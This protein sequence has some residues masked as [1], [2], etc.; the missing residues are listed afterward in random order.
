MPKKQP[1]DLS[2]CGKV[3]VVTG[4]SRGVGK[5]VA[6][7]LGEAGATVYITGR[8]LKSGQASVPLS[9]T[10]TDTADEITQLGG[11]GIACKCDHKKDA[12]VKAVFAKVAKQQGRLD[13]LVNNA[14]SGYENLHRDEYHNGSFWQQPIEMWDAKHTVGVRSAFVAS[15]YAAP[16]MVERNS[17]LIVNISY[18]STAHAEGAAA[19]A[20]AKLSA[21]KM[22]ASMAKDL[23]KF[24]IAS[25]SLYPGYVRTEGVMRGREGEPLPNTESPLYVGRAAAALA[26]DPQIIKKTGQILLAGELAKEYGF[27]DIDGTQPQPQH[28][29]KGSGINKAA[30]TRMRKAFE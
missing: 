29:V 28:M 10:L 12:Q 26:A 25:V 9:G 15:V 23:R 20:V 6:L 16:L 21:D 7:A 4:A 3:A 14:W 1:K 19:Y 2:L 17:G 22:A 18:Y 24:G 27:E 30:F 8:T 11:Q 5:G 13:I